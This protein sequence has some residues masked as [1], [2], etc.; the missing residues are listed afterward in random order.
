MN[1]PSED[2]VNRP[3]TCARHRNH[4][5]KVSIWAIWRLVRLLG[6]PRHSRRIPHDRPMP[7]LSDPFV[8]SPRPA[9]KCAAYPKAVDHLVDELAKLPGIGRRDSPRLLPV[10][11]GRADRDGPCQ[12]DLRRQTNRPPL[13]HVQQLRRRP[14]LWRVPG[15][16]TRSLY[17]VVEQP[18]DLI[19]L[20]QTGAC[21]RAFTTSSWAA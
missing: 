18:K 7:T 16:R 9:T 17:L 21:T 5:P 10:E 4:R 13:R 11:G 12:G 3:S 2:F 6:R 14:P 19:A 20:E 8:G 15:W 1:S